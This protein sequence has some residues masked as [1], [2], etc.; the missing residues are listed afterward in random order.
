[1]V[2][3]VSTSLNRLELLRLNCARL[4]KMHDLPRAKILKIP[5]GFN[6]YLPPGADWREWELMLRQGFG[7]VR[8]LDIGGA[9][10]T[11][12]GHAPRI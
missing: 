10:D 9:N 11:K 8:I 6:V 5:Q 12:Q 4:C 2:F 1:M 3:Q 7:N